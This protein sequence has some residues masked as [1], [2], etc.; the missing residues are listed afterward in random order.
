MLPA[1]G[2]QR[3]LAALDEQIARFSEYDDITAVYRA[4]RA[5]VE[6]GSSDTAEAA[7]L[8]RWFATVRGELVD[9]I[10]DDLNNVQ[11]LSWTFDDTFPYSIGI[12]IFVQYPADIPLP[13]C[14]EY[15]RAMLQ[16]HIAAAHPY[17][18]VDVRAATPTL[19]E[20]VT[21]TIYATD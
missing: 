8:A 14:R 15:L 3:V 18:C 2:K 11:L 20:S 19:G 12:G 13:R 10:L 6:R 4:H 9:C 7:A 1:S 16:Q 21:Y 17:V 5:F